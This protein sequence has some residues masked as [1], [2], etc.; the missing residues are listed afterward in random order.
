MT[1][2]SEIMTRLAANLRATAADIDALVAFASGDKPGTE[3]VVEP[4]PVTP[5]PAAPAGPIWAL[6]ALPKLTIPAEVIVPPGTK[7]IFIPVSVD[8]VDRQSFFA[9]IERL[10]NVSGGGVNVGTPTQFRANFEGV[11]AVYH[12]SP[13]DDGLHWVRIAPRLNGDRV[14][15][16]AFQVAIRVKGL[17]DSQKGRGVTVRFKEGAPVQEITTPF[18]RPLRRLDLSAAKRKNTFDPAA[19]KWSATG[20]DANGKGVLMSALA[21]GRSQDGNG[22]TG[23]YADATVPG[24][25]NPISYDAA[26]KAIRLHTHAF[27]ADKRLEVDSRLWSFQAAVLQGLHVDELC[28]TEGVWRMQAKIPVRKYSWP[29]FWLINRSPKTN[30]YYSQW[31]GEIDILEK[32]NGI[33]GADTVYT[34]SFAQ[35]YGNV[36]SNARISSF[37]NDFDVFQYGIEK[38]PLNERYTSWACH[39]RYDDKDTTKSEVTFFVDDVEVGCQIL[40]AR[41]QDLSK[42]VEFYPIFNV[43]VKTPKDYAAAT[44]NADGSGDMLVRDVAYYPTGAKLV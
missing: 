41:H 5:E 20:K 16:K 12:W 42:K 21:H 37:G 23:L 25:V 17:G 31:P 32:F 38:T 19:V 11:E 3:P 10:V 34:S 15:G 39:V 4:T 18:H 8:Q 2:Q 26:E 40:Y 36:G 14:A 33:Y 43:A 22:E 1:T 24:A 7:E 29:A 35:H 30:G 44:Y 6:H 28:G 27:E 9:Y 13:G